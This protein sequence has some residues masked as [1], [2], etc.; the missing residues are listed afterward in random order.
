MHITTSH[1][2][3]HAHAHLHAYAH[4]HAHAH[5]YTYAHAPCTRTM[6]TCTCTCTCTCLDLMQQDDAL[7]IPRVHGRQHPIEGRRELVR[8]LHAHVPARPGGR[9]EV[10]AGELAKRQSVDGRRA[11]GGDARLVVLVHRVRGE[12]REALG[13]VLLCRRRLELGRGPPAEGCSLQCAGW[14]S[15]VRGVAASGARG[16][17]LECA[18]LQARAGRRR[19]R[20]S[21]PSPRGLCQRRRGGRG[22]QPSLGRAVPWPPGAGQRA[23][24]RGRG[25]ACM[26]QG[27]TW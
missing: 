5:A 21:G 11:V 13:V 10:C 3:K 15:S 8:L 20:R 27:L 19:T 4:Q 23:Q 14:Q 16:C 26:W 22:S 18:G 12:Q 17:R 7:G 25:V 24:G 6:C 9:R 2:P 1:A